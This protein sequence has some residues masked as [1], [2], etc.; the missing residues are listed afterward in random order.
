MSVQS[1]S[2]KQLKALVKESVSEF[3]PTLGKNVANDNKKINDKAYSD[4]SKDA[5]DYDGG[6]TAKPKKGVAPMD[7]NQGMQDLEYNNMNNDFKAKVK[8]QMKGYTSADAEKKHKNDPYGNADFTEIEGMKEKHDAIHKGK[9][10]AKEIG[11]TSREIDKKEFEN[12]RSSVFEG[13]K[14]ITVKFKKT[15]FMTENHVLTK[16]PDEFKVEGKTIIMKDKNN[17]EYLVEWHNED[18]PK[19]INKT[20][21]IEEQAKIKNLFNYKREDSSSNNRTRLQEEANVSDMLGKVRRLMN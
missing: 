4:M 9:Q 17:T 3:K 13:K 8:S 14:P 10:V 16:V 20:K 19:I 5:K 15:V 12:L 21:I 2:V 6:K 7:D 1:Y 11:L 18:D